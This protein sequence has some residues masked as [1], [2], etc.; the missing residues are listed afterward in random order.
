MPTP[1]PRYF[2][3]PDGAY[4]GAFAG[5]QP[6]AGAVQVPS[7]PADARQV[8]SGGAWQPLPPPPYRVRRMDAYAA[9]LG[10]DPGDIIKTLGDVLD[11]LIAQVE[12]MRVE[13]G[14]AA[15]P[16]YAAMRAKI[17]A[18]KAADPAG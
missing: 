4:I 6:P 3:D 16:A 9:Q 7:P 17:A 12:A 1:E 2:V 10:K 8:W 14:L 15:T 18:I 13:A 5:A 11:T